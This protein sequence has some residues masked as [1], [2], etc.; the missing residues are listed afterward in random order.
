MNEKTKKQETIISRVMI[1]LV[2]F[3]LLSV[4][5]WLYIMPFEKTTLQINYYFK[6][7]EYISMGVTLVLFVLSLVFVRKNKHPDT[8]EKAITSK[9]L[10]LLSGAA[11]GGAVMIPFSGFRNRFSKVAIIAFVFLFLAYAT[12]HLVHKSFAYH[13]VVCGI[14]F[15]VLKLFGDYYTTNVTFEDKITMTYTTARLLIA[16]LLAVI[17]LVSVVIGRKSKAFCPLYSILLC[18]VCALAIIVRSFVSSYVIPVSLIALC[19]VFVSIIIFHK[20]VKK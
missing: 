5:S 12:Y 20:I 13:S 1:M 3:V 7:I 19:A 9:M 14:L 4:L 15:I 2:G 10:A 18:A 16:L 17:I 8:F 6:L 11:F